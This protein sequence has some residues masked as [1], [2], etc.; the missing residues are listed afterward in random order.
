MTGKA[1]SVIATSAQLPVEQALERL[2]NRD[3]CAAT[4]TLVLDREWAKEH[5]EACEALALA[6][7]V[8]RAERITE[9]EEAKAKL[10]DRRAEAVME[11]GFRHCSPVRYES[12][13]AA[14]RPTEEQR[15]EAKELPSTQQPR[16]APSFRPAFVAETL[17]FPVMTAEEVETL[18]DGDL[19]SPAE[20]AELFMTA[21]VASNQVTRFEPE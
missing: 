6:H 19:L 20:A 11:F 5:F 8:G 9:C 2:R 12:L 14:H 4:Y 18:F 7:R 13:L 17:L 15:Q 1:E 21:L 3:R 10:A 16:W